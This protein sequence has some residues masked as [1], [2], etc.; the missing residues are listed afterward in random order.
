MSIRY[1]LDKKQ[2]DGTIAIVDIIYTSKNPVL[3]QRKQ[4]LV[5][6]RYARGWRAKRLRYHMETKVRYSIVF[7]YIKTFDTLSNAININI[8]TISTC[9]EEGVA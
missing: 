3:F 5:E 9:T 8:N 7:R 2:L 4:Y 6:Y 1:R